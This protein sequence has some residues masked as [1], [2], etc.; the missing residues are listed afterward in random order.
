MTEPVAPTDD[1]SSVYVVDPDPIVVAT[2]KELFSSVHIEAEYFNSADECLARVNRCSRGCIIADAAAPGACV[3]TFQHRLREQG[4]ELPVI[5]LSYS[6]DVATAVMALKSGAADFLEKPFNDQTLLDAVHRAI[7]TD[8]IQAHHKARRQEL[9]AR[10]DALTPRE[11][12]V[13]VP[14]IKG[15]SN[16]MIAA[17]LGLSEKTVELYRSR[18][19]R[20]I[21]AAKLPELIRI[22]IRI[23]LLGE[24]A[25]SSRD[26]RGRP[27]PRR[28]SRTP[29]Q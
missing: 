22:A 5:F 21:G 12:D 15:C 13:V 23:D 2:L 17:E 29:R 3:A 4:I 18:I 19:M 6:G 26:P 7:E 1:E 10:F 11:W 25:Q 8:Q 14:M 20:K 24:M 16:R 28:H 9:R 27:S